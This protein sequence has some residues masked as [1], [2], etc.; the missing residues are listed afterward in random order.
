MYGE[1]L[2]TRQDIMRHVESRLQSDGDRIRYTINRGGATAVQKIVDAYGS[3][4][5]ETLARRAIASETI[6]PSISE[7]DVR[8][9]CKA[10]DTLKNLSVVSSSNSNKNKIEFLEDL[11][12]AVVRRRGGGGDPAKRPH[13]LY[14]LETEI[15]RRKK[16][17]HPYL[18]RS[19][20]DESAAQ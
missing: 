8:S 3:T 5:L 17:P 9:V 4:I 11:Q 6:P 15:P 12:R 1:N 16:K 18:L 10:R 14:Y 7:S 20:A 19:N 2:L 13:P